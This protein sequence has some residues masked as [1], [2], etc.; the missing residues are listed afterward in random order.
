MVSEEFSEKSSMLESDRRVREAAKGAS[1]VQR[2]RGAMGQK[3]QILE[4]FRPYKVKPSIEVAD[5]KELG[6]REDQLRI[7]LRR[8]AAGEEAAKA[9][10]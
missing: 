10:L 8:K 5:D 4:K 7:Y 6:Y 2:L 1:L 9:S 3:V